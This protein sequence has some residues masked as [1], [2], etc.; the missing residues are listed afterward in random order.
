MGTRCREGQVQ[1]FVTD[2]GPGVPESIRDEIFKRGMAAGLPTE[3]DGFGLGLSIVDTV[4]RIH[5]GIIT[6]K[7]SSGGG[8]SFQVA[9]PAA[10]EESPSAV[11]PRPDLAERPRD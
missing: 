11:L 5:D 7:E 9:L 10:C 6:L 1:L 3:E 8:S 2:Q 4:A